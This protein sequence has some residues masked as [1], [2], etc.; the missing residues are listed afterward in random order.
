MR[1][2]KNNQNKN[3]LQSLTA[4]KYYK[5]Y[6]KNK[7]SRCLYGFTLE[8]T[9]EVLFAVDGDSSPKKEVLYPSLDN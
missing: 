5:L 4:E 2:A 8:F 7:A 3:M 9:S 1:Y 6:E